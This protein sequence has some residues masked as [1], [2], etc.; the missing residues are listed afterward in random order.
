[1]TEPELIAVPTPAGVRAVFTTR[2]GGASSGA[3]AEANLGAGTGDDPA[4]VR[5][6]REV[7]CAAIGV[8]PQRVSMGHQVH[9]TD[10]RTID[11]P[12]DPGRFTGDLL[13]WEEGDGLATAAIATPLMVLGADCMPI[14]LWRADGAAV[15][16]V[17]AGWRGL[18]AGIVANAVGALGRGSEI[19]AAIGPCAGPCCYE[20]D[21]ELRARFHADYG[22][23][24]VRARAVDLAL[25]ARTELER[26]GV[27]GADVHCD[28]SCTVCQPA[29]FFSYR[30]D[31]AVTGRQAAVIWRAPA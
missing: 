19:G 1:M 16:A 8:D 27:P 30:R 22:A 18:M 7:L 20:V 2:R 31:G 11:G 13:G 21:D 3:H 29:R 24:V 5:V 25:A 26:A 28:G 15:A 9:G 10:V 6:N 4:A 14:V 12:A 23:A 17:H